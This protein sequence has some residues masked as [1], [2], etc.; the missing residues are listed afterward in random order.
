MTVLSEPKARHVILS[1]PKATRRISCTSIAVEILRIAMKLLAQDDM[2][3][4]FAKH[5]RL[6]VGRP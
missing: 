5:E 6:F 1:E 4:R 2:H 3:A